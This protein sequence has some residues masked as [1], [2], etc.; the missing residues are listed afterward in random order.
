MANVFGQEGGASSSSGSISVP[1]GVWGDS[2]S[3]YGVCG[4]TNTGVGV[5]GGAQITGLAG[6]FSGAVQIYG[7]Q[8]N[9]G[10]VSV[11]GTLN[12]T[13]VQAGTLTVN[14]N[15]TK[16]AGSFKIDHP[17]DPADKYL[18]HSFVESPDMKNIY[19]GVAML[20]SNGEVV[21]ELPTWF[22][23]LNQ[24]FRYQLT[25]LGAPGPRL[26][27]AEK[28][29]GSRFKI[30]G[31]EPGMEVSWQVTGVRHD[32]YANA[33]RIQVEED[34]PEAERGYYLHPELYGQPPG[35]SIEWAR[36]PELM[37]RVKEEQHKSR[38]VIPY[39]ALA[40]PERGLGD[41]TFQQASPNGA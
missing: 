38:P 12:V 11:S 10:D 16:P 27:I 19:D 6:Y 41:V 4:T 37:Q 5:F 40:V 17:L 32:A 33:H 8:T 13:A 26:H 22:E 24:D 3:G 34:K 29:R 14:Y 7:S 39:T 15:L 20:D 35:E 25:P 28:I 30:A 1:M 36:H 2:G 21:V 9:T 18:S 31:G 23:P